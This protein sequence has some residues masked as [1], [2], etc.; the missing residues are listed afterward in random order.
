MLQARM[1]FVCFTLCFLNSVTSEYAP[2]G[3]DLT[4]GGTGKATCDFASWSP[5]L[6]E[7]DFGPGDVYQ[8]IVENVDGT[9]PNQAFSGIDDNKNTTKDTGIKFECTLENILLSP[10]VFTPN[11]SWMKY[12]TF[13]N[14][15]V[16]DG[17]SSGM[18][19]NMTGLEEF[20]V[21]GGII[22]PLSSD[23]FSGLTNLVKIIINAD[24]LDAD[25]PAG[26]FT[27][28]SALQEI[29]LRSSGISSISADTFTNLA[30]LTKIDLSENS[31]TTLPEGMF[32]SL[33]SLST[34]ELGT[35]SWDCT[36]DL[37]WLST[38]SLYT[39]VTID[40]TCT[41][42]AA[43]NG[44]PLSRVV[45]S[46]GCISSISSSNASG[47]TSDSSSSGSSSSSG[48]YLVLNSISMT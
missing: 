7:G 26:L 1:I 32:T 31:L 34:V 44:I 24:F 40:V 48:L 35:N 10:E 17:I 39:G 42:P 46:L 36:C 8:I 16:Q 15:Y 28:L 30:L 25:I 22:G 29:D 38:W 20:T 41:T 4:G 21:D 45:A 3:C 9:I 27:S 23:V 37:A 33:I 12:L 14:C 18:L 6:D 43:Y 5:P 13:K 19:S 2:T 11:L 47:S